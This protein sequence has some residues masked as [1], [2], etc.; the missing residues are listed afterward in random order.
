MTVQQVT[1]PKTPIGDVLPAADVGGVLI[2][3]SGKT[4]YALLRLD[5]DLIDYLLE[6]DPRFIRECEQI[7]QRM[8]GGRFRAH[9]EVKRLLTDESDD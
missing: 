5:D 8:R 1:D 2:E 3:S 7:R 6:H 9:E 4:A